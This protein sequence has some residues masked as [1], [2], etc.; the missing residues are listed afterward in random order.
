M[1]P[2]SSQMLT[3]KSWWPTLNKLPTRWTGP[4]LHTGTRAC[5]HECNV[6]G[7]PGVLLENGRVC[8][9]VPK[10]KHLGSL[11]S[12]TSSSAEID[13]K[14]RSRLSNALVVFL[15]TMLRLWCPLE[16]KY[17]GYTFSTSDMPTKNEQIP[18]SAHSRQRASLRRGSVVRDA[19]AKFPLSR[20]TSCRLRDVFVPLPTGPS[21]RA[22]CLRR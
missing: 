20:V 1:K 2:S 21:T 5:Q 16:Y 19:D 12:A 15:C 3:M 17:D 14:L 13:I 7:I 8:K 6:D 22:S 4:C 18:K 10:Y 11:V 9:F